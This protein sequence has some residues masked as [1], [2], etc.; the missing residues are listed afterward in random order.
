VSAESRDSRKLPG[1]R[2]KTESHVHR[3]L[4]E[5][6]RVRTR[7]SP[8]SRVD[9]IVVSRIA[10]RL[11]TN[12]WY[13]EFSRSHPE[14]KVTA[15]N[16]IHLGSGHSIAEIE[17]GGPPADGSGEIAS[18]SDVIEVERLRP[19]PGEPRYLV[20]YRQTAL[21]SILSEYGALVRYPLTI[22]NGVMELEMIA[23]KSDLR[24]IITSLT[25]SGGAPRILSLGSDTVHSVPLIL[26]TTQR[27][28]FKEALAA[29]YFEVPR[30]ITLTQL[31]QRVSRSKSSVSSTLAVVEQKLAEFA[32]A[33]G[34]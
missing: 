20:R 14:L 28:L 13:A 17:I 33:V 29:G 15:V 8:R 21:T 19:A 22:R 1:R 16:V 32:N 26:T 30:R 11:P 31:A 27:S 5:P 18:F 25:K 7:L 2:L 4:L 6:G 23:W 24:R 9:R 10:I 12:V 34:G 3:G